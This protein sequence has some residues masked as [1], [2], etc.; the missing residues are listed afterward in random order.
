[1]EPGVKR[2]IDK[3]GN[4]EIVDG[5]VSHDNF[6]FYTHFTLF[7]FNSAKYGHIGISIE[8]NA[9]IATFAFFSDWLSCL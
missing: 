5:R 4:E 2:L 6:W 3:P 7:Y 9:P 8:Q 1:M